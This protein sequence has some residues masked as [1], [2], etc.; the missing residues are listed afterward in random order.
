MTLPKLISQLK[1]IHTDI[2]NGASF[3]AEIKLDV[4]I[5]DLN[6]SGLVQISNSQG[7]TISINQE[8]SRPTPDS[9]EDEI[10]GRI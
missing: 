7:N 8:F 4:L 5:K 3:G 1:E 6:E 2:V 9:L 10:Q